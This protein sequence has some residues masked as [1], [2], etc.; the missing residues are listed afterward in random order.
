MRGSSCSA[1]DGSPPSIA[2][3]MRVTSLISGSLPRGNRLVSVGGPPGAEEVSRRKIGQPGG[4]RK[5]RQ[6]HPVPRQFA[7]VA[8]VRSGSDRRNGCR[9]LARVGFIDRRAQVLPCNLRRS[10]TPTQ[11]QRSPSERELSVWNGRQVYMQ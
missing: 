8:V 2:D 6:V 5:W 9:C 3:K 1:A 10:A 11:S 4:N 7:A